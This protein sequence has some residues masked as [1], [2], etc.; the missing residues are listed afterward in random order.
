MGLTLVFSRSQAEISVEVCM[1]PRVMP[2]HHTAVFYSYDTRASPLHLLDGHV[3]D[4]WH[5]IYG[6]E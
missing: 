5:F 2:N 4:D 3:K 6:K 1:N